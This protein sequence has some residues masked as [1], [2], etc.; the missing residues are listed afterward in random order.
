MHQG[1][2]YEYDIENAKSTIRS[3]LWLRDQQLWDLEDMF[4]CETVNQWWNNQLAS[5]PSQKW[6]FQYKL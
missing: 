3:L 5:L 6:T 1:I 4:G 2:D